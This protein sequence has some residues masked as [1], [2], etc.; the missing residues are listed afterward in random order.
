MI[1]EPY[2]LLSK[3]YLKGSL[4]ENNA[5]NDALS[6][7]Y[8]GAVDTLLTVSPGQVL[9]FV[10]TDEYGRQA[11]RSLD[12]ILFL[13]TDV[14]AFDL[15]VRNANDGTYI[16]AGSYTVNAG[17][18]VI[19]LPQVYTTDALQITITAGS[20]IGELKACKFL[21][22]RELCALTSSNYSFE[23]AAG[24]FRTVNGRLIHYKDYSKWKN[25]LS[26]SNLIKPQ[27]D[28]IANEVKN[29]SELTILP[30]KNFEIKDIYECYINPQFSY[31]VDRKTELYT[32]NLDCK[33]L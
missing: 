6:I 28:A 7:V 19:D 1:N 32:L 25:S 29:I 3:N 24:S 26:I 12:K 15:S 33:E 16:S 2:I 14:T 17:Y 9:T 22:N 4:D 13:N 8:D 31:N 5:P 20:Y 27:F 23:C 18:A 11:S 21:L 10:L 30:F